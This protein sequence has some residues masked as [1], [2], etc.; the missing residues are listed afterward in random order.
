MKKKKDPHLA[1][2]SVIPCAQQS[3]TRPWASGTGLLAKSHS[4]TSQCEN[5]KVQ[6]NVEIEQPLQNG[7]ED[8]PLGGGNGH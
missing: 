1:T 5:C 8:C 6:K 4:G 2:S 7:Q 3:G